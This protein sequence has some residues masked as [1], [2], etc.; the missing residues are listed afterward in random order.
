[1]PY[2]PLICFFP[3]LGSEGRFPLSPGVGKSKNIARRAHQREDWNILKRFCFSTD[4]PAL[5]QKHERN[6][7]SPFAISLPKTKKVSC[8]FLLNHPV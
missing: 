5:D 8:V 6:C 7:F 3:P 1:M 2:F 4:T